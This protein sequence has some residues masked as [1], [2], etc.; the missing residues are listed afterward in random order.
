MGSD[1]P[2]VTEV[3]HSAITT[4]DQANALFADSLSKLQRKDFAGAKQELDDCV[5]WGNKANNR[6]FQINSLWLRGITEVDLQPPGTGSQ[7]A[8][9]DFKRAANLAKGLPNFDLVRFGELEQERGVNLENLNQM[10]QAISAFKEGAAMLSKDP[11]LANPLSPATFKQVELLHDIGT[12][13]NQSGSFNDAVIN[14]TKAASIVRGQMRVQLSP[15][16]QFKQ[17]QSTFGE[18]VTELKS[19]YD[20][21]GQDG[22]AKVTELIKNFEAAEKTA[23]N[24]KS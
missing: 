10:P 19:S 14:L 8:E 11:Q 2:A 16:A 6:D 21:L 5:S 18:I 9:A 4:S 13:D 22:L 7:P 12:A 1:V 17:E 3:K 15:S 23:L 20:S 24:G